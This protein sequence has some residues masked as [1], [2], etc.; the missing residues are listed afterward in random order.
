MGYTPRNVEVF[1]EAFTHRSAQKKDENGNSINFERLEFLGDALLGASAAM[2][3]YYKAPD[4]QEGYLTKM[5]SKIDSRKQLIIFQSEKPCN[6][7]QEGDA[8]IPLNETSNGLNFFTAS[9]IIPTYFLRLIF[10]RSNSS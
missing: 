3:L 8:V 6:I 1:K 2:H 9:S 4:Q 5:R 10:P 7:I